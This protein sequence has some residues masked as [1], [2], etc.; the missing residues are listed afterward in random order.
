M[1]QDTAFLI[2]FD[3]CL[4]I[5]I[6]FISNPSKWQGT[7]LF[8]LGPGPNRGNIGFQLTIPNNSNALG[9]MI[10]GGQPGS[11]FKLDQDNSTITSWRHI[12]LNCHQNGGWQNIPAYMDAFI[13][14]K[15]VQTFTYNRNNGS[16]IGMICG[17]TS[18]YEQDTVC[19]SSARIYNRLLDQGE[20]IALSKELHPAN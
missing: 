20:I 7:D 10:S 3:I 13:N 16:V 1:D 19:L 6:A 15:F 12:L 17:K 9:V 18:K 8:G 4:S 5:W 11:E 2:G 14:G